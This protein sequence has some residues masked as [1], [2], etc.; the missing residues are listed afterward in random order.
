MRQESRWGRQS[1]PD[2]TGG[3]VYERIAEQAKRD[4]DEAAQSGRITYAHI[5]EEEVFEA[6]AEGDKSKLKAELVQVAAVALAW[7]EKLIR[8]GVE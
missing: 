3:I 5:L 6:L 7:I 2:G 4:T 8:E 1:W